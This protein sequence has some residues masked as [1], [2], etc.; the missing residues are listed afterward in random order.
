MSKI[1]LAKPVRSLSRA[2]RAIAP[3]TNTTPRLPATRPV[4]RASLVSEGANG[5]ASFVPPLRK[6]VF[7][8]SEYMASSDVTRIY[9]RKHLEDL[10]RRNPHV[11]VVVRPRHNKEPLI[12]G[13][14]GTSC[15]SYCF[16]VCVC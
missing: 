10:A 7:E 14:Y 15:L 12:T 9:L 5:H 6:I 2:A 16:H 11:E 1:P 8:Y 3:R 13:F 4:F